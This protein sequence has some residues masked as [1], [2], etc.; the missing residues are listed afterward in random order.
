MGGQFALDTHIQRMARG[1][2]CILDCQSLERRDD[3]DIQGS[4]AAD[5]DS[6]LSTSSVADVGTFGCTSLP[7][8][9]R[10]DPGTRCIPVQARAMQ[11]VLSAQCGERQLLLSSV[12]HAREL[13]GTETRQRPCGPRKDA[14]HTQ[15]TTG[16]DGGN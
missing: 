6:T 4:G 1:V 5:L 15:T 7:S 11:G 3:V 13:M 9:L 16:V 10:G 14:R 2:C 8:L 12:P